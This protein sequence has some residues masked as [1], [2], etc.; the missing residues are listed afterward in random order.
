[1]EQA[2][3]APCRLTKDTGTPMACRGHNHHLKRILT[4]T[5]SCVGKIH[6]LDHTRGSSLCCKL[7]HRHNAMTYGAHVAAQ[8]F[9]EGSL[10]QQASAAAGCWNA[11]LQQGPH[12]ST[13]T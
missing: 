11:L 10:K 2:K 3:G 8:G 5:P 4:F 9:D 12:G 1:M 6:H 7:Q 13:I